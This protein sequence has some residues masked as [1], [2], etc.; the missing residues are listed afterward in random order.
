MV[1]RSFTGDPEIN[2][3]RRGKTESIA[4]ANMID[5]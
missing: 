5:E 1:A 4:N 2:G 3:S